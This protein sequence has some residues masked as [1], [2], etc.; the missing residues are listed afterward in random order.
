MTVTT[1]PSNNGRIQR[2][3]LSSQPGS[4]GQHFGWTGWALTGAITDAVKDAVSIAVAEAVRATLIEVVTN[5]DVL[6]LLR[7]VVPVVPA[8]STEKVAPVER[9]SIVGTVRRFMSSAWK[10]SLGKVRS[11]VPG[12]S[13]VYAG[14]V[15]EL[16]WATPP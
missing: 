6:S 14:F 5:P 16:C 2:K 7:G 9:P 10:C 15:M 3:S 13:I 1:S 11:R 4:S 8:V 12:S